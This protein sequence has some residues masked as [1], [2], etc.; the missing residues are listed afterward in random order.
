MYIKYLLYLL[1]CFQCVAK[2]PG[3]PQDGLSGRPHHPTPPPGG[4]QDGLSGWLLQPEGSEECSGSSGAEDDEPCDNGERIMEEEISNAMRSVGFF[5]DQDVYLNE[6]S[7]HGSLLMLPKD[8]LKE[9]INA[10]LLL[11]KHLPKSLLPSS[12][13]LEEK[14]FNG[15]TQSATFNKEEETLHIKISGLKSSVHQIFF[16]SFSKKCFKLLRKQLMNLA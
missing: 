5:V 4:L 10:I 11:L 3:G 1:L 12:P 8:S 7:L 15:A 14:I 16:R 6:E 2:P 13:L 9:N